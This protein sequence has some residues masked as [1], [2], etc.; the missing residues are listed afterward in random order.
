MAG[1]TRLELATSAVTG[2]R[3]NQ[4]N[5]TPVDDMSYTLLFFILQQ[6]NAIFFYF[7]KML[8]SLC[9]KAAESGSKVC[10]G[11]VLIFCFE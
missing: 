2:Q 1:V 11:S 9:R 8:M 6:K 4:L 7:V 5:H 10:R 3:S